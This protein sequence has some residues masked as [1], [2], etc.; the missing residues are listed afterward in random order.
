MTD[1][2][3]PNGAG[4][5]FGAVLLPGKTIDELLDLVVRTAVA[6]VDE[7]TAVS[8]TYRAKQGRGFRTRTST[9]DTIRD[10]DAV[11][12]GSAGPCVVAA[13]SGEECRVSLPDQRFPEFSEAATRAGM[14]TVW[15]L[16]L[17]PHPDHGLI[18]A[19]NLY[20]AGGR[21]W[22]DGTG[23]ALRLLAEQVAALLTNAAAMDRTERLNN[24]LQEALASRTVIGQAQGIL[25]LRQ[26]IDADRSFDF[27]RRASQRTNRK[28]RDIAAEVVAN[29]GQ[30]GPPL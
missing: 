10:I 2:T 9:S 3:A 19:L 25:M 26:G 21:P 14:T 12:Y 18:G 15:S 13:S 27:L 29:V 16:P 28:L 20:S 6:A 4:G 7:V 8:V 23:P 17:N 24:D 22:R 1:L 30:P 5:W 11:Q